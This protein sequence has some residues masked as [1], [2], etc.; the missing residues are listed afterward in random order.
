MFENFLKN[1]ADIIARDAA[2]RAL[3]APIWGNYEAI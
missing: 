3:L 1:V 2:D